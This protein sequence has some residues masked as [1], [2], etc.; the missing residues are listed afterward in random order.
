M[1][2]NLYLGL[3]RSPIRRG[4]DLGSDL[5]LALIPLSAEETGSNQMSGFMPA[6]DS[7]APYSPTHASYTPNLPPIEPLDP[8]EEPQIPRFDHAPY[9]PSL[10]FYRLVPPSLAQN[11]P[12][13]NGSSR[14]EYCPHLPSYIPVS[15]T[16]DRTGVEPRGPDASDPVGHAPYSPSYPPVSPAA[17][18]IIGPLIEGGSNR[19]EHVPY[20]PPYA[21]MSPGAL[22]SSQAVDALVVEDGDSHVPYS[23]P[24]VPVSLTQQ[25]H[26]DRPSGGSLLPA[27]AASLYEATMQT[28]E[29]LSQ[30]GPSQRELFRYPEV[31]L[32]RLIESS[33]RWP[34]RRFRSTVPYRA[35]PDFGISSLAM[36]DRLLQDI[37]TTDRSVG[38]SATHKVSVESLIAKDSEEE[39]EEQGRAAANFECNVC[40]DMARDPVVTSCG[41]LFCWPC[42]YQRLHVHCD[43]KE[44]PVCKGEVTE[45]NI[46]PIYGRGS[47]ETAAKK[48]GGEDGDSS[49]KVPPRPHGHR[50]E[51]SR[52][53]HPRPLSR[54]LDGEEK[55]NGNRL[56]GED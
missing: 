55:R 28:G 11:S 26:N 9:T 31:R 47:T 39:K 24:Y 32:R 49:L 20:S 56:D 41:H 18:D 6:S 5:A 50:F 51:S 25:L 22:P 21:P 15:P 40:L 8:T 37:M 48:K 46:T 45:S 36:E 34:S 23:P 7:H 54:K 4:S 16:P 2:L 44:C 53:R 33:R 14:L 35:E 3:P 27:V 38:T 19:V 42:L 17:E 12:E 30:D 29:P 10:P 52:Q 43:H 1:D 13:P